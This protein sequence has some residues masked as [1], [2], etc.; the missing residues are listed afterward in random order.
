MIIWFF[1]IGQPLLL[2]AV[3]AW[4]GW[5]YR[6]ALTR[7]M[8]ASSGGL[9]VEV[10]DAPSTSLRHDGPPLSIQQ[11]RKAEAEAGWATS[12]ADRARETTRTAMLCLQVGGTTYW[13]AVTA[14]QAG[15]AWLAWNWHVA[16]LVGVLGF[17]P[18]FIVLVDVAA[19][20]SWKTWALA[21]GSYGAVAAAVVL[22]LA[23]RG[24]ALDKILASCIELAP[25]HVL[26]AVGVLLLMHRGLRNL[27]VAA[28]PV[29]FF[30]LVF[31]AAYATAAAAL[32]LPG[33]MTGILH[34]AGN[35]WP[36]PVM[37]A[38]G[39]A[40]VPVSVW[41]FLR[42]LR[43]PGRRS[44][45]VLA[46]VAIGLAA[47]VLESW[48]RP[49]FPLGPL[50]AG[51]PSNLLQLLL[52]WLL[53]KAVATL[54]STH[55][56]PAEVLHF[57]LCWLFLSSYGVVVLT[58]TLAS[59]PGAYEPPAL[60][61]WAALVL[62]YLL[63]IHAPLRS[64][65]QARRHVEPTRL[66]FLRVFGDT[67]KRER[68]LDTLDDTWRR[69]GRI[70]LIGA[71]DVAMRTLTSATLECFV[72]QRLG[73]AFVRAGEVERR[74]STLRS[75]LEGDLR[76]PVNEVCCYLDTWQAV[77]TRLA[78]ASDMVLLDLRGFTRD[79]RGCT[80]ELTHLVRHVDLRHVVVLVDATTDVLSLR[81]I[82][83][84]A[85][86]SR[87][88]D[89]DDAPAS[90]VLRLFELRSAS[91]AAALPAMLFKQLHDLRGST[92]DRRTT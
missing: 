43:S 85:W 11:V 78:P 29:I 50:I 37:L 28:L 14:L 21:A 40:F 24:N 32:G 46:L 81:E 57:H 53:F 35:R 69:I 80:F 7:T 1:V 58:S 71:S 76:Y 68:L 5:R 56:M 27:L 61:L 72:L 47:P 73:Q 12:S 65:W 6:K 92:R 3:V 20:R 34:D 70:D 89:P 51:I 17:L 4:V 26:P 44:K 67:G 66:L 84:S 88:P 90:P 10:P 38:I 30:I 60:G 62:S 83:M 41:I 49:T 18:G 45:P 54:E 77:V 79:N 19:R 16:L 23:W 59:V 8:Q 64:A 42:I 91:D 87:S 22:V 33:E 55:W 82:A 86:A 15:A 48:L 63:M 39:A 74:L 52:I 25:L 36:G 13:V 31:A 75:R 9:M 2:W